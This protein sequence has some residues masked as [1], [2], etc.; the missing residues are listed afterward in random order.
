[1]RA[2]ITFEMDENEIDLARTSTV[3]E[4][5]TTGRTRRA[6]QHLKRRLSKRRIIVISL[7][8]GAIASGFCGAIA[9]LIS[10]FLQ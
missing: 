5:W 9:L 6:V 7:T 8:F 3:V 4:Y 1:M 10:K 2:N